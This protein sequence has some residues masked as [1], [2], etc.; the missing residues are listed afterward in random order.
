MHRAPFLAG[1]I[2][3]SLLSPLSRSEEPAGAVAIPG[4]SAGIGFDDLRYSPALK[5]VLVPAGRTG[6]LV[7]IDP[8]NQA[9]ETIA[10]FSSTE[11]YGGGHGEG[12]TSVDEGGGVLYVTDRSARQL[13]VVDPASR[14]ILARAPLAAS[15][16]YVRYV[17]PTREIWVTEPDAEQIEVFRL[18]PPGAT[19]ASTGTISVRDGPES[20]VIDPAGSR[21]YTHL[22]SGKTVVIDV[23]TRRAIAEWANGCGGSRGIA[24]DTARKQLFVGCAEGK[25][26]VLSTETGKVLGSLSAGDGVDIIDFDPRLSH[27][28]LPGGKSATMAI[29]GVSPQ[30][31]LTLLRT[32]PTAPGAHCAVT[33]ASGH[34]YVCDPKRGRFLVTLDQR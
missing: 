26:V 21:A 22:W 24:L 9:L 12:I 2:L 4:G 18:G 5:R 1:L 25:A 17:A 10:G 3:A 32:V 14:K 27:F 30:G 34:V 13:E 19:P 7:L 8:V 15:P 16:D 23:K 31:K 6:T 28:Y 29:I 33:D 11:G 20:L